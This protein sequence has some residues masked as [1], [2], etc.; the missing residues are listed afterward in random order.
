MRLGK[1][2]AV[3][4]QSP[5]NLSPCLC[6]VISGNL[7]PP[8][9]QCWFSP[10]WQAQRWW[11]WKHIFEYCFCE[12]CLTF[13]TRILFGISIEICDQESLLFVVSNVHLGHPIFFKARRK[14]FQHKDSFGVILI[15]CNSLPK[16]Y[17]LCFDAPKLIGV[18]VF[19]HKSISY[20]F[21]DSTTLIMFGVKLL[22]TSFKKCYFVILL[23]LLC[24]TSPENWIFCTSFQ[25]VNPLCR[26][27][28]GLFIMH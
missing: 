17:F 12:S 20:P 22:F 4:Y 19:D 2:D 5:G 27:W 14:I 15:P 6:Q 23:P 13:F 24:S 26:H 16:K 8:L 3:F 7:L 11:G 10:Q 21:F 1:R 18:T 9:W 25:N 28:L